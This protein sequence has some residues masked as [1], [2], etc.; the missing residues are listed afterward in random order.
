M[1]ENR[2]RKGT[3]LH[4]SQKKARP[5]SVSAWRPVHV[6]D[7]LRACDP[8]VLAN[9]ANAIEEEGLSGR[10]A[11]KLTEDDLVSMTKSLGERKSA[12]QALQNLKH[13]LMPAFIQMDTDQSN[14]ISAPELAHVLTRVKGRCVTEQ[15]ARQ[16]IDTADVDQSGDVDFQEFKDILEAGGA[17]DWGAAAEAVG[18]PRFLPCFCLT[19]LCF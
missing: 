16:M 3:E 5:T 11:V 10:S 8:R 2:K 13:P 15:E 1:F 18:A 14:T 17:T 6:A 19:C 9:V 12:L 7:Y 4:G